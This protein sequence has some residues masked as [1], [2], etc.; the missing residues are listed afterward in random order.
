LAKQPEVQLIKRDKQT[1]SVT[2]TPVAAPTQARATLTAADVT[3]FQ[4]LLASANLVTLPAGKS[5]SDIQ[6]FLV[7]VQPNGGGFL[8]VS[9]K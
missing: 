1:M 4:T 9:I 3:A 5:A 8:Q 6:Q 2:L 7:N